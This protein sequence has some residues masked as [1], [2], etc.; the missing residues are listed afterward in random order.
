[1][2]LGKESE[3]VEFKEDIAQMDKGIRTLSAM[4]NRRHHGTVYF[5]VNDS[6]EVIGMDIG[7]STLEK[8]RNAIRTD[9]VP[10]IIPDI[11]K[12]VSDDGK[13]YISISVTGHAVPYSYKDRYFIRNISS[14]ESAGPDIVAQ[15]VLSRGMDPLRDMASDDQK[16]SFE[17]LFTALASHGHHPRD[18]P[19]Y[20]RSIGLFDDLDHFNLNAYLLSD[21]NSIPMQIVE[22]KGT[23][24]GEIS[25]RTDFGKGSLIKSM[26]A[27]HD[28]IAGLMETV[29]N[30][31]TLERTEKS[32]FDL[33]AFREAWINACVHNAWRSFTPPS[34]LVFENRMEVISYGK[35][36]F[37]LS[38]EEFF[39]GDSRPV[40]QGLFS[41][42]AKLNKIEQSGHGV[43]RIVKAYGREAFHIT[44]SGLK[45]TLPFAF[46]PRFVTLRKIA[47]ET[48]SHL[49]PDETS[50]LRFLRDN[51]K[52]K[53]SE[54]SEHTGMTLSSV[55]KTVTVLKNKGI[56][57]NEGTN[58]NSLWV[59]K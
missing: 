7:D 34:V 49:K 59:V 16:L 25:K 31:D 33:G 8:F 23:D 13:E 27:I 15:L 2:N 52:A 26:E 39:T 18:D 6:G 5:G 56:L 1:T 11:R 36:P 58:R 19:N 30:T 42:F 32:L 51:P 48:I 35:I 20:Y 44:D 50:V 4:L 45:V 54:V 41:V 17:Y 53:L 9:I 43:P 46:V 55:K 37:P 29:V 40:N 28:H 38:N 3:T 21:Q 47:E 12:M 57:T 22:F 24:R 10:H 14:D